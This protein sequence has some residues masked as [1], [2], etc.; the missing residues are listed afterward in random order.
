M[1]KHVLIARELG[2]LLTARRPAMD[3]RRHLLRVFPSLFSAVNMQVAKAPP[4]PS[5]LPRWYLPQ[6][7]ST[8]EEILQHSRWV[9]FIGA[10]PSEQFLFFAEQGCLVFVF[11]PFP[12]EMNDF[13]EQIDRKMLLRKN[14]FFFSGSP[15]DFDEPLLFSLPKNATEF[16]TPVF[17]VRPDC[18]DEYVEYIR[19]QIEVF[20][21]H[22]QLYPHESLPQIDDLRPVAN[23]YSFIHTRHLV[24]NL[25][26]LPY[27]AP[28][29]QLEGLCQGM[30]A[31]LIAAGPSLDSQIDTIRRLASHCVLVCANKAYRKL[32][33]HNIIP[34]FVVLLDASP[35]SARELAGL[36]RKG[37]VSLVAYMLAGASLGD[38]ASRFFFGNELEQL[39]LPDGMIPHLGSVILYQAHLAK[40]LGCTELFMAGL[41]LGTPRKMS[42]GYAAGLA[43]GK[44]TD[45]PHPV[46][47]PN[48]YTPLYTTP[49]FLDVALWLRAWLEKNELRTTNLSANSLLF[50]K[51]IKQCAMPSMP[52][53]IMHRPLGIPKHSLSPAVALK[54]RQSLESFKRKWLFLI[55]TG[56]QLLSRLDT[57]GF[58]PE[59]AEL[60]AACDKNS[61]TAM[62]K[63]YPPYE[64]SAG[65]FP[66]RYINGS[67]GE[68]KAAA[69]E[70]LHHLISAATSLLESSEK[71]LGVIVR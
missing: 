65:S 58:E 46:F 30:P 42:E 44:E 59:F 13:I 38:F 32:L 57:E 71:S 28:V 23:G 50:G 49:N 26:L 29:S 12:E 43:P 2:L 69:H 9:I 3:K 67:A 68:R 4:L 64:E 36:P 51:T 35:G 17:Y 14:I 47:L 16:G 1:E 24:E 20:Y 60:L 70:Y 48:Q 61:V 5:G 53:N 21:Y 40:L 33:Q 52:Q 15:Q 19:Q 62:L 8:P 7:H 31:V 45:W 34:D 63:T 39:G 56:T 55:E 41:T 11:H 27:A 22:H 10:V 54:A 18:P 6:A 37:D 25:G 66:E